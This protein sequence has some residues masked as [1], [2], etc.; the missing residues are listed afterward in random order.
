VLNATGRAKKLRNR[1][2]HNLGVPAEI[3]DVFDLAPN[4]TNHTTQAALHGTGITAPEFTSCAPN[5]WNYWADRHLNGT[6][7][8]FV[9]R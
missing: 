7:E 2:A 3:L 4:F 9:T 8:R 1:M 5:L 6:T